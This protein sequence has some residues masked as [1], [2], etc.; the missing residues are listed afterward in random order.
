M[1]SLKC[2]PSSI[3]TAGFLLVLVLVRSVVVRLVH[4][5]LHIFYFG[6]YNSL[7]FLFLFFRLVGL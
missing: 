4:A 2:C 5:T 6:W 7:A 1:A 3:E